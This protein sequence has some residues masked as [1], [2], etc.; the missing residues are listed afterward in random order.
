MVGFDAPLEQSQLARARESIE[1][2]RIPSYRARETRACFERVFR[3]REDERERDLEG[4]S[5]CGGREEQVGTGGTIHT[6]KGVPRPNAGRL[7]SLV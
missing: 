4:A 3:L 7:M 5:A 1:A 2:D 6:V